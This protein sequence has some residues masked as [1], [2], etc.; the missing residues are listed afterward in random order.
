MQAFLQHDLVILLLKVLRI[1]ALIYVGVLVLLYVFQ[2]SLQYL[3][4]TRH[5][6]PDVVGYDAEE[7]SLTTE[8]GETI[9]AWWQP[10]QDERPVILHFHGNAGNLAYRA[11]R[12]RQFTDAGYGLL[13]ITYRGYGGST[14]SP[15]EAALVRD[16]ELAIKFLQDRAI[17]SSD[18]VIYGESLGTGVAV[19]RAARTS[20]RA[21][22]LEAPFPSAW[23]V[24][25]RVY[26]IFPVR[27]LMKDKFESFRFI[28]EI[29]APL[30]IIHGR[31]D[32]VI[33][34]EFGKALFQMASEPK[35]FA[36]FDAAGH[37]D[38]FAHGA[39]NTVL[40]FLDNIQ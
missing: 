11:E 17:A 19:Q 27:T 4:D 26:S 31:R 10:P 16:S 2:R 38:L 1:A 22:I 33:P 20:I 29:D 18:I 8:D 15:N 6:P 32:D 23:A 3:P 30:L 37:N 7:I 13:A 35:Q 34:F 14:G 5:I 28:N 25:K 9:Y 39:G 40:E 12:Y 24:A 21:L 36:A